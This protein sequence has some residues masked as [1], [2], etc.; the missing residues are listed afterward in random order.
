M[1]DLRPADLKFSA[2]TESSDRSSGSRAP[3]SW[4]APIFLVALVL[5]LLHLKS[6][7]NLFIDEV[8]YSDIATNVASGHGVTSYGAP[9]DLHPPLV[10]LTLGGVIR[11]FGVHGTPT[12]AILALR[13]VSV[14]FG[15]LTVVICFLL[16]RRLTSSRLLPL[17]VA[18]VIAFDPFQISF[19]SRVML[20]AEAQFFVALTVLLLACRHQATTPRSSQWFTLLAGVSSG[21]AF[22]SKET[23]GLVLAATLLLATFTRA[24]GPRRVPAAVLGIGAAIYAVSTLAI[25]LTTGFTPWW[26]AHTSG[27]SR[28][29]GTKQTTGFNAATTHVSLTDRLFANLGDLGGTYLLLLCGGVAAL[30]L[31]WRLRLWERRAPVTTGDSA[32]SLICVWAVAACGYLTYAMAIGS[33]EEQ[34]YYITLVP[35]VL[36]LAAVVHRPGGSSRLTR[37]A[38]ILWVSALAAL[39]L[40]DAAAWTRIHSSDNNLYAQF[41]QWEP[42]HVAA[43]S[44]VS[45]TEYSAQFLLKDVVIGRW[46]TIEALKQNQADFIL[47]NTE[48]V[49]QGY[50]EGSPAFLK[51][52]QE[53]AD[54]VF[55]AHS[56]S[57]GDLILFDVRR[58]TGE[59]G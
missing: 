56:R 21:A 30:L 10:F 4:A 33:L 58:L 12:N 48:L 29:V 25:W 45:V 22:C 1:T 28:L 38:R 55:T 16:A 31:L 27:L 14:V 50:G 13:P 52:L 43:G 54:P 59:G 26:S 42:S 51:Y 35:C 6:A 19:D 3:L 46:S 34:M 40:F 18:A 44:R 39:L 11:L 47:L 20:E 9:F 49:R 57:D 8:T 15:S 37:R 23:F 41:F 32:R 53:N 2:P 36:S 17:A 5:R 24:A 7:Y